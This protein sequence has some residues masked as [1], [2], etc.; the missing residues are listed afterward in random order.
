MLPA[1]EVGLV[2]VVGLEVVVWLEVDVGLEDVGLDV[3]VGLEVDVWL[4]DVV[5]LEVDVELEDVVWL[6]VVWSEFVAGLYLTVHWSLL[7]WTG[8][9]DWSDFFVTF[10][11]MFCL[12]TL[13]TCHNYCQLINC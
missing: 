5:W 9:I 12:T 13:I 6:E 11:H 7:F 10:D 4:E 3:V 1:F 2:V 8:F